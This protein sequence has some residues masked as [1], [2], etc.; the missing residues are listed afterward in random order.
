MEAGPPKVTYAFTGVTAVVCMGLCDGCRDPSRGAAEQ[1]RQADRAYRYAQYEKS[2]R[3]ASSVISAH[4]EELVGAE[5]RYL[6]GLSRLRQGDRQAAQNDF[7]AALRRCEHRPLEVLLWVQLGNLAFDEQRYETAARCYQHATGDLPANIPADK[8]WYRCGVSLQRSGDFTG[9]RE[10]FAR[11]LAE[12]PA[13]LL[14]S[15]ARRKLAWRADHFSVQCGAFS[16][17]ESARLAARK[18][19]QDGVKAGVTRRDLRTT[20]PYVVLTGRFR[21]FDAAELALADV[22]RVQRDAFIV[23]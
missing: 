5:A 17:E 3:I 12:H 19:R 7:L 1:I 6:R 22:R 23:P 14:A 9:A 16:T 15:S 13:S 18:L 8:V 20:L 4:S 21:N 2:D 10:A 11:L